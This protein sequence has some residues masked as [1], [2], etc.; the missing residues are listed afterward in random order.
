MKILGIYGSPREGGNSDL[1]L[2]R[3][4]EGARSAGAEVDS[5]A[6][7]DYCYQGCVEC[8]GCDQTGVCVLKDDMQI[9]YPKLKEAE[10]ILVATPVFFYGVPAQLK[11]LIDRSQALWAQGRLRRAEGRER[12]SDGG[13]G[14]LIAVGATRGKQLFEGIELTVR[15]FFDALDKRYGGGIFFRQIEGKGAIRKDPSALEK[16]FEFGKQLVS[17]PSRPISDP[18]SDDPICRK[19]N[20]A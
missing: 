11:A 1:L 14:Y 4:L 19:S 16:A 17:E 13:R 20:G 7:R 15:Y 8:G 2:E 5:I 18:A 3:A 6:V 9:L 12:R 10:V